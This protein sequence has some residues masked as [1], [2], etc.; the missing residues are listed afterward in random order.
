M[1]RIRGDATRSGKG[2]ILESH[3]ER[4]VIENRGDLG[5]RAVPGAGRL[6]YAVRKRV[7]GEG[8]SLP[9]TE[10]DYRSPWGLSQPRLW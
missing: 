3:C 2:L 4:L 8:L 5:E 10:R 9:C 1:A 7:P 6:A